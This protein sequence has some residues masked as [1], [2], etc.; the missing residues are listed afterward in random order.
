[1]SS[2][3]DFEKVFN[4]IQQSIA[5][6]STIQNIDGS[7]KDVRIEYMNP[8]FLD[9]FGTTIKLGYTLD[10]LVDKLSDEIC[11][12]DFFNDA[13]VGDCKVE[14]SF[15]SFIAKRHV[16][17]SLHKVD[18]DYIVIDVSD[19]SKI[20]ESELQ[21]RRQNERLASLTEQLSIS[22]ADLKK[23]Y[24][25]LERLNEYLNR[26]A[27]YDPLTNMMNRLSLNRNMVSF[28][29]QCASRGDKFGILYMDIDNL[30]NINDAKGH[31]AGD[32]IIVKVGSLLQG[33]S[34]RILSCYRF[35]GDEFCIL[36]KEITS[37]VPIHNLGK[38]ICRKLNDLS[39]GISGGVVLYPDDATTLDELLKYSD[40]A[41]CEAKKHGKNQIRDFENSM[42]EDFAQRIS[43]ENKLQKAL[44]DKLFQLYYQPQFDVDSGE[45][46]GFEALIRWH[47]DELGWVSPGNFIPLAEEARL[48]IPICDWVFDTAIMT[49]SQWEREKGFDGTLSVNIS[50]LQFVDA[51]F[52]KKL[53]D[54]I[55]WSKINPSHLE[56]EIP[57]S[58][59]VEDVS[60]VQTKFNE[61]KDLG[62][63]ISL[64]DFGTGYSSIRY[65]R[66]L[67]ISTLKIGRSFIQ[68]ITL[69]GN[70]DTE[71]AKS[72]VSFVANMGLETV[73]EGVETE[74]QLETLR[75]FNCRKI[76]MQGFLR[77]KPMPR[78][79]CDKYLGGDKDALLTNAKD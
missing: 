67:P 30:K 54:K 78:Y 61:I 35:A 58:C 31:T 33:Y 19:I 69:K 6:C 10:N 47:D 21:L 5:I 55:L 77:G 25:H 26:S 70:K 11:W 59:L 4:N 13:F 48:A 37:K 40:I 12:L 44:E 49:L 65:L 16:R 52:V 45:L 41:L 15:Y 17:M 79:L 62:V 22:Q 57:E 68:N 28:I 46:R 51:D 3:S 50:R 53:R 34:S 23:K 2:I 56:L 73:A 29:N 71:L 76:K 36:M 60:Q 7:L 27:Y 32:E 38:E 1:M 20:V 74:E 42:K 64:D 18:S 43:I 75:S 14:R 63:G 72:I 8:S 9:Y 39:V 24:E 66:S